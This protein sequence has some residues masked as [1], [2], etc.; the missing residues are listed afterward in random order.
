MRPKLGEHM[1]H[2]RC[3]FFRPKIEDNEITGND[4]NKGGQKGDNAI[5]C[6]DGTEDFHKVSS[7][8]F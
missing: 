3:F 2:M 4:Y 5:N 6:K 7:N 8:I 1:R